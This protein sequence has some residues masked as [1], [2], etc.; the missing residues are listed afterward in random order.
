[1]NLLLVEFLKN[2]SFRKDDL[3]QLNLDLLKTLLELSKSIELEILPQTIYDYL[4]LLLNNK[5]IVFASVPG[6]GGYDAFYCISLENIIDVCESESFD[7]YTF[8]IRD[9]KQMRI[10]N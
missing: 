1:M 7:R 4:M 9:I 3:I 5:N 10:I 2:N 8:D 6:S